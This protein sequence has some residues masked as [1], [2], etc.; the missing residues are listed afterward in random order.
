MTDRNVMSK[1]KDLQEESEKNNFDYNK[2]NL[3]IF[4]I[5]SSW[6]VAP[7]VGALL[8]GSWLDDKY[9]HE[10]FFTLTFISVAFIITCV[11]I[12]REALKAFK[13]LK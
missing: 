10:N 13:S 9:N 8:L 2:T 3:Q 6:I 4:G 12:V 7:I 1:E 11:G 5:I